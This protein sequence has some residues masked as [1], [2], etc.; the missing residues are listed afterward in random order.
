MI[1][2]WRSLRRE[3]PSA[4]R[5]PPQSRHSCASRLA[6]SSRA[7]AKPLP[8]TR[9]GNVE[10]AG[11]ER[12]AAA[13]LQ[14]RTVDQAGHLLDDARVGKYRRSESGLSSNVSRQLP[15]AGHRD[16]GDVSPRPPLRQTDEVIRP[17]PSRHCKS[18]CVSVINGVGHA[19]CLRLSACC[20]RRLR[21]P[22]AYS[23]GDTP[24][25]RLKIRWKW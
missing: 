14:R 7:R 19:G 11:L 3:R 5:S 10:S 18:R 12:L 22:R 2:S 24:R 21:R 9:F 17:F 8:G 1:V 23:D 6:G 20:A 13:R 4:D 25:S 16:R 15:V